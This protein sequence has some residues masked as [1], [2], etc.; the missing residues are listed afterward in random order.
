MNAVLEWLARLP[1]AA[2]YLALG[3]AAAIENVFPPFPADT[4]VAFG[5]FLAARGRGTELGAFLSTWIG[6]VGGAMAVYALSRRYGAGGVRARLARFGDG[7]SEERIRSLY[8][9][10]GIPALFVSRFLPGARAIVPPFAGA[11]R[12]PAAPVALAMATASG[13]WYGAITVLAYRV[14]A[15]WDALVAALGRLSRD[16]ALLA[17]AVVA[18][19]AIGWLL[20]RW[21]KRS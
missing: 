6:N 18:V 12:L 14:G 9:R 19:A 4:V 5:S 8:G 20:H 16:V 17:L 2:L 7:R 3:A 21:H 13:L 15:N 1:P 11:L 10:Y